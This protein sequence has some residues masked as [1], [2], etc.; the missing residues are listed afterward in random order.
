MHIISSIISVVLLGFVCGVIGTMLMS[1]RHEIMAALTATPNPAMA[2]PPECGRA[3][4]SD[5][6][7]NRLRVSGVSANQPELLALAA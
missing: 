4:V 3:Y 2:S 6:I 5:V 1:F 7:P